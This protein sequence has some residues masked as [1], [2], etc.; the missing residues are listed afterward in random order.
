VLGTIVAVVVTGVGALAV[1]PQLATKQETSVGTAGREAQS[2]GAN[3]SAP[4]AQGA[5]AAAPS[6]A[7]PQLF[8][9]GTDYQPATVGTVARIR[10][11]QSAA[12]KGAAPESAPRAASTDATDM[13]VPDALRR[14]AEPAA[15]S[16]CLGAIERAYRGTVTAVDYARFQGSPALVVLLTRTDA[17]LARPWVVVVGPRC[18]DGGTIDEKYNAPVS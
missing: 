11:P 14:L 18:G 4:D 9:T 17:S 5:Q 15:R 13:S 10:G 6:G 2:G 8:A 1:L 7:A 12:V 3:L 16:A